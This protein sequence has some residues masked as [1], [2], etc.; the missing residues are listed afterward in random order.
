[1]NAMR[2]LCVIFISFF[3][4]SSIVSQAV[5]LEIGDVQMPSPNAA[6]MMKYVDI[7]VN[8][9][10]GIPNISIPI[11][12]FSEGSLS[13]SINLTYHASGFKV[14]ENASWVGQGWNL[15]GGGMISRSIVGRA[16]D[17]ASGVGYIVGAFLDS[18]YS[19]HALYDGFDTEPDLFYFNFYVLVFE[20]LA[21]KSAFVAM[22][23]KLHVGHCF[24]IHVCTVYVLVLVH[25]ICS[26]YF[27]ICSIF[28][29]IFALVSLF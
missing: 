7:P 10:T 9:F 27:T 16:D 5:N 15:S 24:P 14:N 4:N 26:M 12:S 28:F 23:Y 6:A 2:C 18:T 19:F 29:A 17:H 22:S 20:F 21:S 1:M 3:I 8:T 25:S 13:E 11:V